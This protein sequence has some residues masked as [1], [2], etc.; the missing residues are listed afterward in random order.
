MKNVQGWTYEENLQG[1]YYMIWGLILI[2][3]SKDKREKIDN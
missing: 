1:T 3:T 2:L